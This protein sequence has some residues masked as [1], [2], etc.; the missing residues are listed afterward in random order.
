MEGVFVALGVDPAHEVGLTVWS[1]VE[2]LRRA[3]TSR[4]VGVLGPGA[5]GGLIAERMSKAD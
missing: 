1:E 2:A 4:K 5:I 3:M